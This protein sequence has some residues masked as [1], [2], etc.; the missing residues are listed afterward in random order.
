L[1]E[2]SSLDAS[3]LLQPRLD[4]SFCIGPGKAI[5]ENIRASKEFGI[6]LASQQQAALASIAGNSSGR[7]VD[8][9]VLE[10]LGYRFYKAKKIDTL[11]VY[12]AALNLECSLFK[13]IPLGPHCRK[14]FSWS[15]IWHGY[16]K[17]DLFLERYHS[18]A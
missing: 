7:E 16:S 12:G 6:S 13:E 10:E 14:L 8:K 4:S 1:R 5:H 15:I 11:M 9:R 18:P 3:P 17:E 2:K